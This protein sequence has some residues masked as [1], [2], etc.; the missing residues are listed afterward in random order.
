VVVGFS[1]LSTYI[2]FN[3]NEDISGEY[4]WIHGGLL[5]LVVEI[6]MIVLINFR[7]RLTVK[8]IKARLALEK[9]KN[10]I[11]EQKQ[12]IETKNEQLIDSLNYAKRIQEAILGDQDLIKGWFDDA[13]I[14]FRPKDIVSG[15]FYWLYKHPEKDIRIVIAADCTGHGVPAAL[16]TVLG[17]TLITDIV[18]HK[19]IYQPDVILRQLDASLIKALKKR[20]D[21]YGEVNDGMDMS[22]LSF[23][24]EEVLF[25]GAKN[26]LLHIHNSEARVVRGSKFPIGGSSDYEG[27]KNFEC[28][29]LSV[30]KGDQVYIYSDGFQDQFGGPK[31]KKFMTKRMRELLVSSTSQELSGQKET[32]ERTFDDWKGNEP[33]TDDVLLIGLR[34]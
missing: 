17:N 9:S 26:P 24:D 19:G 23:I 18:E 29:S 27:Q 5:K 33:Q 10:L 20:G 12:V 30:N 11:S 3:L 6:F 15:D 14:I 34:I 31:G 2:F 16:M 25:A 28:H 7:Y 22:V 21:Q 4:F 8:E 1:V 13:F 32:L